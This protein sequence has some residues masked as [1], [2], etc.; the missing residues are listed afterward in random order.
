MEKTREEGKTQKERK[1]WDLDLLNPHYKPDFV[2]GIFRSNLVKTS[3]QF[4]EVNITI[5]ACPLLLIAVKTQVVWVSS[6][7]T[8]I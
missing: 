5:A 4:C 3:Q 6:L 8:V 7:L 1:E 2:P